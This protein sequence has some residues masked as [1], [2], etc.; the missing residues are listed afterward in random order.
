MSEP[1]DSPGRLGVWTWLDMMGAREAVQFTRSIERWGYT[2]LWTPEAVGRDPFALIAYLA[3][4]TERIVLATGIAN[5]YA[6]DAVTMKAIRQTLGEML[7]GRFILGLGVSHPHLVS[8]LRGHE[9]RK[10]VPKMREYLAAIDEALYQGPAPEV[11]APIVIA[12]LRPLMLGVAREKARGAH[13][14]LTTPEHTRRAREIL[15]DE[16]WLCPEQMVIRETD[17]GKAREVARANLKVYL[18]APN[19]QNS[20]KEL[21]YDDDDF[22]N[23]GSDRLVDALVAWGDEEALMDRVR[24]HWEAGAD[25]VCIQPFRSDGKPG[26]DVATLEALAPKR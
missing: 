10:P 5:I 26:P 12:A 9:W 2:T 7:P 3:G 8:H 14:Y 18:R 13:P 20:L 1:L 16:R 6:R 22:A 15:G 25:H 21:G 4:Q 23:G 24:A 11:E 17:G 19:Y